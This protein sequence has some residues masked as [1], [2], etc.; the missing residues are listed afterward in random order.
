MLTE[1]VHGSCAI[2][3]IAL[4]TRHLAA[5]L[6]LLLDCVLSDLVLCRPLKGLADN[7]AYITVVPPTPLTRVSTP[8]QTKT[9]AL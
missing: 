5:L 3:A 6:E 4:A 9:L 8:T 2:A 7:F 1:G